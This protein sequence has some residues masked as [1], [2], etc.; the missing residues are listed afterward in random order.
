VTPPTVRWL[1]GSITRS[2]VTLFCVEHPYKRNI[3][4]YHVKKMKACKYKSSCE[5]CLVV[6]KSQE[7]MFTTLWRQDMGSSI[8]TLRS[9]MIES[10]LLTITVRV[11]LLLIMYISCLAEC[12]YSTRQ[13]Q[14]LLNNITNSPD[15][16]YLN[17]VTTMNKIWDL[18]PWLKSWQPWTCI[19]LLVNHMDINFPSPVGQ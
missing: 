19:H 6:I 12:L 17:D 7:V 1:E 3:R 11:D 8:I 15:P 9:K 2:D 18:Q 14:P 5:I 4:R 16:F 13:T 10:I